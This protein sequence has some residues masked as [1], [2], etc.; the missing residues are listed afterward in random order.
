MIGQLRRDAEY[1]LQRRRRPIRRGE[2]E[3][4]IRSSV[5]RSNLQ[6]TQKSQIMLTIKNQLEKEAL[7]K[8]IAIMPLIL[9]SSLD[10]ISIIHGNN[11]FITTYYAM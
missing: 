11:H 3:A 9:L 2:S 4:V 6:R 8:L 7:S 5:N 10:F 1:L